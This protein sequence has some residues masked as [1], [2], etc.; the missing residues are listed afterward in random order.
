MR[1]EKELMI[2]RVLDQQRNFGRAASTLNMT[3]PA[4]TRAL[5][6]IEKDLGVTLFERSKRYVAPTAQG[7]AA[8]EHV[9]GLIKGFADLRLAVTAPRLQDGSDFRVS[10]GP[11]AAE[12]V[13][14]TALATY[15][16]RFP[17]S[18]G[19]VRIRDWMTCISDVRE[20]SS[21]LA[22]TDL[23]SVKSMS[24]LEGTFLGREPGRFFCRSDHPLARV[25][26]VS[27]QDVV[28]FPWAF[29]AVQAR[30]ADMIPVPLDKAGR[31]DPETGIFIP[32]VRVETFEAMK[33]AVRNGNSIGLCSPRFLKQELASGEMALIDLF[34]PWMYI[35]YGLI[36]RRGSMPQGP[37][38]AF[39]DVLVDTQR[40]RDKENLSDWAA[41][42]LT[43]PT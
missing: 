25:N 3:Q 38:R 23:P 10:F 29:T 35:S 22:V 31:V 34:E 41:A 32:A 24:D 15:S 14:L 28:S 9:D 4:L 43:R 19:Q 18:H 13:G 5:Q 17:H 40:E 30:L 16:L 37:L 33:A 1:T 11:L 36:W 27:W 39:V 7:Q 20:G 2:V 8:L 6:R 42:D 21:D 12:A 26:S